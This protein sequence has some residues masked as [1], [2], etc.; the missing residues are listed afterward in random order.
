MDRGER[1][2]RARLGIRQGSLE[3]ALQTGLVLGA[4]DRPL[5]E[6]GI[7][8]DEAE[9]VEVVAAQWLEAHPRPVEDDRLD[10]CL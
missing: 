9:V 8:G 7:E 5:P 10:P 1:P 6:R 3:P 4:H 2:F